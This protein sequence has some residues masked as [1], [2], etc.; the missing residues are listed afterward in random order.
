MAE[1]LKYS[2]VIGN[3]VREMSGNGVKVEDIFAYIQKY[4]GA[5]RSKPTF[6]KYYAEDLYAARVENVSKVGN[7]VVEQALEGD[8]KSQEL[9]LRSRGGWS[10]N[11]TVNEVE[12]E[13]GLEGS[14]AINELM[15]LLGKEVSHKDE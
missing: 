1:A 9:F 8:F 3:K 13:D 11:S 14:S 7:K 15:A 10:P 4:Q 12:Q 5:P 6:Y 2:K